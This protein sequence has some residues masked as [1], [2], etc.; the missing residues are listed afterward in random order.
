M[1]RALEQEKQFK[2]R[3][4]HYFF[5]PIAIAKGYLSLALEEKDDKEKIMKAIKAIDRVEKVV[6]NI[7]QRGVITE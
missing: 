4:A 7:T 3:A 2:L 1:K 6:K 5:N